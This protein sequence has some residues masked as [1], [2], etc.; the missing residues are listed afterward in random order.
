MATEFLS[1]NPLEPATPVNDP[2]IAEILDRVT[3]DI[4]DVKDFIAGLY[5]GKFANY[6]GLRTD[7]TPARTAA[8][9]SM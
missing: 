2:E 5:V 4:L 7:C 6:W 8:C 9:R 1:A 3:A